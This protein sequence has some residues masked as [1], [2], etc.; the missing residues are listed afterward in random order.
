MDL[1]T[2][3]S[4]IWKSSSDLV[5]QYKISKW[6][7][8]DVISNLLDML[9]REAILILRCFDFYYKIG[10]PELSF[11]TIFVYYTWIKNDK[12]GDISGFVEIVEILEDSCVRKTTVRDSKA[13]SCHIKKIRNHLSLYITCRCS[14]RNGI[15]DSFVRT[16]GRTDKRTNCLCGY[17]LD[18]RFDQFRAFVY[19][20]AVKLCRIICWENL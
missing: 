15:G 13:N 11:S 20:W 12:S 6:W 14:F 9:V 8:V 16:N 10:L 4:F 17:V 2:I 3:R 19:I 1:R 18:F 5:L 7:Y